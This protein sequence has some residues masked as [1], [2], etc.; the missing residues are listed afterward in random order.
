M[1]TLLVGILAVTSLGAC[2]S[3]VKQI[4][5]VNMISNRN[6]D[7]KLDYAPLS[8]YAGGSKSELKKA[9]ETSIEDAIDK[10]VRKVPGGEFLMNAKIFMVDGRYVVVEGDVWG[11][12]TNVAHRGFRVGDQVVWKSVTG[13]VKMGVVK[14]LKDD[15]TC[16][17]ETEDGTRVEKKYDD[18]SKG[19]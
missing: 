13:V 5:K 18:I 2:S 16:F 6:I 8:T 19:E 14:S 10:T 1:K 9:K 4:G 15:K 12:N 7:P 3:S 11:V 17:V